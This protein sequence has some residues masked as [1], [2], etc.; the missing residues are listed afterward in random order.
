MYDYCATGGDQHTLCDSLE[1]Y[2]VACQVAG[3]ELPDWQIGTAC[4]KCGT[5]WRECTV[6]VT[7]KLKVVKSQGVALK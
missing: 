7:L 1:S 4:G 3:V 6:C 5:L 2:A